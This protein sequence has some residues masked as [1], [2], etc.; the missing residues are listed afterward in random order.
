MILAQSHPVIRPLERHVERGARS[1]LE[2]AEVREPE[3]RK[4]NRK[5]L[6]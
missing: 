4:L 5:T 3:I 2:G 1:E 6:E